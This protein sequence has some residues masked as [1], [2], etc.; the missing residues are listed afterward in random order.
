MSAEEELDRLYM[1]YD[2]ASRRLERHR[3]DARQRAVLQRR[4]EK[5]EAA[6][7]EQLKVKEDAAWKMQQR[8]LLLG[9]IEDETPF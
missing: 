6:I 7:D 9:G 3:G 8:S 5:L 1:A 4:L 2:D